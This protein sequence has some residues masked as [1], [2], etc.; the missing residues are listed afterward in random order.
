MS[1]GRRVTWLPYLVLG[2]VAVGCLVVAGLRSAGP[3]TAE[4]RVN[5]VAKTIKCPTCQGESVADSNAPTSREIR[6]DIADR[7]A[8]GETPDQVRAAYADS[9]GPA[10]L[11]TPSASGVTS[12]VWVL[13]VVALVA[14]VV[15]LVVVF[16]RWRGRVPAPV[17]DEDRSVVERARAEQRA[18]RSEP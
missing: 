9:Y 16:R 3:V 11:L 4:D 1:T 17:T 10:I 2:A 5:D 8:R 15:G 6:R 12:L 7:L 13:P 18:A 14:A